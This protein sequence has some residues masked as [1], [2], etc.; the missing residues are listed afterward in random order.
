VL[1]V[2]VVTGIVLTLIVRIVPE[3]QRGYDNGVWFFVQ[4][5]LAMW[6]FAAEVLRRWYSGL[7]SLTLRPLFAG[8]L[9]VVPT[10]AMA[11]PSTVQHFAELAKE[12]AASD[13]EATAAAAFLASNVRPGDVVLVSQAVAGRIVALAP[14]RLPVGYFADTM[15]SADRYK[16]REALVLDFW[17]VWES[18]T[19]R[20][21]ILRY[22]GVRYVSAVRPANLRV[23]SEM[24]ELY[25]QSDYVVLELRE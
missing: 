16:R 21:D 13:P 15:V 10:I 25:S 23:P 12:T 1:A 5:K 17:R 14:V 9:V 18:G 20:I 24:S 6:I 3:G 7:R 2:Y 8:I 22:L 19:I 4:S 11:A